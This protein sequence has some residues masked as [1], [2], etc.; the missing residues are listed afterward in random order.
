MKKVRPLVEF[1]NFLF[2]L[3][4]RIFA[5]RC[6]RKPFC[7]LLNIVIWAQFTFRF[8]LAQFANLPDSIKK[9]LRKFHRHKIQMYV[10]F[11]R[12]ND[13]VT[14]S[15]HPSKRNLFFCLKYFSSKTRSR[16]RQPRHEEVNF[17]SAA[18]AAFLQPWVEFVLTRTRHQTVKSFNKSGKNNP[19]FMNV[20]LNW[21]HREHKSG[22]T[23]PGGACALSRRNRNNYLFVISWISFLTEIPSS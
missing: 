11:S 13:F 15:L 20:K 9:T 1:A 19:T 23:G 2:N 12:E 18:A 6:L 7:K 16:R 22:A 5:N 3:V 14:F 17:H 4:S 21:K 10:E 8:T